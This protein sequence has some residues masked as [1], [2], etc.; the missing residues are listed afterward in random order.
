MSLKY[1]QNF[2]F[3][4]TSFSKLRLNYEIRLSDSAVYGNFSVFFSIFQLF[5]IPSTFDF[6]SKKV[7][8]G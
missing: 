7:A 6:R 2:K 3:L 1:D 4:V 8:Q 5:K